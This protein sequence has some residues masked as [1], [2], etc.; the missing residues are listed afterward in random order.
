MVKAQALTRSIST[1][2]FSRTKRIRRATQRATRKEKWDLLRH[3]RRLKCHSHNS[4]LLSKNRVLILQL[5]VAMAKNEEK[6]V[7]G[8]P[9]AWR[10]AAHKPKA[11]G[12]GL[13]PDCVLATLD[14]VACCVLSLNDGNQSARVSLQTP[15][16]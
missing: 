1:R 2:F 14:S 16:Y 5:N 10:I 11:I 4:F 3:N 6:I 13:M 7:A 15:C 9:A 8:R 12:G